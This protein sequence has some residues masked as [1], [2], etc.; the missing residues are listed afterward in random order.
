MNT[1]TSFLIVF[2][3]ISTHSFKELNKKLLYKNATYEEEIRTVQLYP[4][5]GHNSQVFEPAVAQLGRMNLMLEFDDLVQDT[6]DYKAMIIHCDKDWAKS[7]LRP[8]D[9]LYDYNEFNITDDQF[10]VDTK[11]AYVHY[12]F[13][14]PRVK[15][16]GNYLLVAYRGSNESDIILSHR[17]MVYQNLVSINLISPLNGFTSANRKNQQLDFKVNYDNY[18]ILNPLETVG[19]TLRKNQRWDN[20]IDDLKPS[21]IRDHINEIEYR[22]FNFENNFEGGNEYR[23]FD[24]RSLI[25]PGQGVEKIDWSTYPITAKLFTDEPKIYQAYTQQF[26]DI[27]GNYY[28]VN[29]DAGNG[30]TYSDYVNTQFR[31][32]SDPIH[33]DIYVV[34]KMNNWEKTETNRLKYNRK[35]KSYSTD[36]ILKQGWYDYKYIVENDTLKANYLEGSHYETEN[37]YEILI[38]HRPLN[39]RSDLLVGYGYYVMNRREN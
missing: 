33:G 26:T 21:F 23:F 1:L 37:A 25:S 39:Q 12:S 7:R 9:Y 22:F 34:G 24:M 35:S 15:L 19:I 6:E 28:I 32:Q 36:L 5:T 16:P 4:L 17:F 10:S 20:A 27:N 31:L 11:I 8:L 18:E 38:Y 29:V 30:D 2:S 13:R 14:L 3:I